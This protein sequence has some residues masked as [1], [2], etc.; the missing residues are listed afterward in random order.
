MR[1]DPTSSAV[2]CSVARG[3]L[4]RLTFP[5]HW[6]PPC[7]SAQCLHAGHGSGCQIS[8]E[9]TT[10]AEEALIAWISDQDSYLTEVSR[11]SDFF[12]GLF[13][14]TFGSRNLLVYHSAAWPTSFRV[15]AA[16]IGP[17]YILAPFGCRLGGSIQDSGRS[18]PIMGLVCSAVP[19]PGCGYGLFVDHFFLVFGG[20]FRSF[21]AQCAF[22]ASA[23]K[24]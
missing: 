12:F 10:A 3:I 20:Q 22:A 6:Y 8:M 7:I 17:S 1:R 11:S 5:I 15:K 24:F 23:R 18:G 2:A 16:P 13:L 14:E 4:G 21:S 9:C 19:S